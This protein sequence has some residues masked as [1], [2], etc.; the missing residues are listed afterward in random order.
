MLDVMQNSLVSTQIIAKIYRAW[1]KQCAYHKIQWYFD[2][3]KELLQYV[4]HST[5]KTL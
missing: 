2:Q 1:L 5:D 3:N 4:K